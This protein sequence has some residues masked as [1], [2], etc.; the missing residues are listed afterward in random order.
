MKRTLLPLALAGLVSSASGAVLLDETIS[1][2]SPVL[3][4]DWKQVLL[5][6]VR[7]AG[8][9]G[10]FEQKRRETLLGIQG[11]AERAE[12]ERLPLALEP[13]TRT[14]TLVSGDQESSLHPAARDA[15][16][17]L[18]RTYILIDS[19]NSRQCLCARQILSEAAPAR[20]IVLNGPLGSAP[21]L[22][23]VRLYADQNDVFRRRFAIAALPSLIRIEGAAATVRE[24]PVDEQGCALDPAQSDPFLTQQNASMKAM[25]ETP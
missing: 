24:I 13:K 14:L 23:G 21:H 7:E 11:R 16:K 12:G 8:R 10:L 6:R 22:E 4:P 15:V 25:G 2:T 19:T 5:S 3:E 18:R 17:S 20:V 9:L 1:A